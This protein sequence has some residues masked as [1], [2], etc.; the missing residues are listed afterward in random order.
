M[1]Y[2]VTNTL[3]HVRL[4]AIGA[5]LAAFFA[6]APAHAV[7]TNILEFEANYP[8]G[9]LGGNLTDEEINELISDN[10]EILGVD[11]EL[12]AKVEPDGDIDQVQPGFEGIAFGS[13]E[14]T[15][16][17]DGD[18]Q[19]GFTLTLDFSG[20]AAG[21]FQIVKVAVKAGN[22]LVGVFALQDPADLQTGD[23]DVIQA[24]FVSDAD[25]VL[26]CGQPGGQG[27][28]QGVSNM[29]VFVSPADVALEDVPEPATLTLLGLGL[30]GAGIASRRRYLK[31]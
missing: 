13:F 12:L 5:A 26:S 14:C 4:A 16:G 7:A 19:T 31:K 28:C 18:C 1:R 9:G 10:S 22:D 21:P 20:V 23:L 6:A 27:G 17:D 3:R 24:A 25:R 2:S 29:Y 11:V 30:L 8:G 15:S